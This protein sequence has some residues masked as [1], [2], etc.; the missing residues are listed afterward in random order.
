MAFTNSISVRIVVKYLELGLGEET[1]GISERKIVIDSIFSTA[2]LENS[3][4][5]SVIKI[6]P[7]TYIRIRQTQ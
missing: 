5:V 7:K 6:C 3:R 2:S 4:I 1:R